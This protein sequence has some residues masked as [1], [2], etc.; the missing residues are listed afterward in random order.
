M[1][2]LYHIPNIFT[3]YDNSSINCKEMLLK[4]I[5]L[6][7]IL[8]FSGLIQAQEI[9]CIVS[10]N[11]DQLEGN[12]FQYVK[13]SL[14]TNLQAYI[15]EYQWTEFEY[16]EQEKIKCQINIILLSGNQDFSFSAE[17]IIQLRRPIYNSTSETTTMIIS[18]GNWQFRYPEGKSLIHDDTEFEPLTGF[19]DYYTYLMLGLDFDSF[20]ML[21]GNEWYV[22]AQNMLDLAQ[23]SSTI[24]WTR[25]TNNGRNRFVLI[26]DLLNNNYESVRNAFYVYHRQ[27]LDGFITNPNQSRKE[28]VELLKSLRDA[29]QRSTNNYLFDLFFGTKSKELASILEDA[30]SDLKFEAYNILREVD[31]ANLTEYEIL[32]N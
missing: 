31:S 2:P 9:E 6:L 24:G 22:K 15:N 19:I 14:S 28:L 7:L 29:K 17:T 1:K 18:D 13:N 25:N 30:D 32:Q 21:G 10:I 12:S 27:I 11:D 20:S 23:N 16:Q 3:K 4:K 26:S 8:F 5:Y